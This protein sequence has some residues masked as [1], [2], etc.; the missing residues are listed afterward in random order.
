ML[1]RACKESAFRGL[2]GRY[3]PGLLIEIVGVWSKQQHDIKPQ[4]PNIWCEEE[5]LAIKK[6]LASM[7][8]SLEEEIFKALLHEEELLTQLKK[9]IR[10]GAPSR[11]QFGPFHSFTVA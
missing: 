4:G 2:N 1:W 7:A 11:V 3:T 5:C 10:I 6:V 8:I 9:D